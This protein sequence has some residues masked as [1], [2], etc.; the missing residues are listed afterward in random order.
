MELY[1]NFPVRNFYIYTRI[2][3][4]EN[5]PN[6]GILQP[7]VIFQNY[8]DKSTRA[9]FLQTEVNYYTHYF[10][11]NLVFKINFNSKKYG[12]N[13]LIISYVVAVNFYPISHT[14]NSHAFTYS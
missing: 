11:K 4:Y 14:N 1:E 10:K 2:I 13:A 6:Y 7:P 12:K 3:K 9:F 8:S 5:F